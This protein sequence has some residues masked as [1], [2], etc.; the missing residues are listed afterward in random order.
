MLPDEIKI[1]FTGPQ[2][3]G[4][5]RLIRTLVALLKA[6]GVKVTA[7]QYRTSTNDEDHSM[8]ITGETARD[9]VARRGF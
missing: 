1:T 5:S 8:I 4:K 7:A 6:N 2:G 9:F 3:V